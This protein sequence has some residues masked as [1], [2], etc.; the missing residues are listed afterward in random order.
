MGKII[1]KIREKKRRFDELSTKGQSDLIKDYT[2]N[3]PT[4]KMHC[5]D[6]GEHLGFFRM[7][8]QAR[9]VAKGSKYLVTCKCCKKINIIVKGQ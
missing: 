2:T 6:C 7:Y 9:K 4:N 3:D 8:R 5:E 1:N